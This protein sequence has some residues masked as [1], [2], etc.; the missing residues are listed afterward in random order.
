LGLSTLDKLA[1]A[2]FSTGSVDSLIEQVR[3]RAEALC[4]PDREGARLR[5]I[6]KRLVS[7]E[8]HVE[9]LE[10]LVGKALASRD[11]EGLGHVEQLLR[12]FTGRLALLRRE[13]AEEVRQGRRPT[14]VVRREAYVHD[15]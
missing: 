15:G 11:W 12:T 4:G 3:A 8:A 5:M 7:C 13:H 6:S 9:L 10:A 2:T 14:I 1:A